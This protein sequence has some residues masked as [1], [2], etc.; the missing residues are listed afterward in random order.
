MYVASNSFVLSLRM[1]GMHSMQFDHA[2][3]DLLSA[4]N[5]ITV[6]LTVCHVKLTQRT[7]MEQ[8]RKKKCL[9]VGYRSLSLAL[10]NLWLLLVC[11][12][13][14]LFAYCFISISNTIDIELVILNKLVVVVVVDI[15]KL[16][17][18]VWIISQF[19]RLKVCRS[20]SIA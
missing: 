5:L 19:V 1:N 3:L 4:H 7:A 13:L 18:R 12:S 9:I 16:T 10:C 14:T 6:V 15:F 2:P 17:R 8:K 20:M 11:I